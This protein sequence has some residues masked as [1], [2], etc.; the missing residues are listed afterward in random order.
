MED[1]SQTSGMILLFG[2]LAF[3]PAVVDL[4]G[5]SAEDV[6][7]NGSDLV[8]P[9]IVVLIGNIIRVVFGMTSIFIGF[10]Y[11]VCRW[12]SKLTST[13]GLM[14]TMAAWFPFAA[15]IVN[16]IFN[17]DK[18][19][20]AAP[21]LVI[22][23]DAYSPTRAE[24]RSIASD[25]SN[26]PPPHLLLDAGALTFLHWKNWKFYSGESYVYNAGYYLSRQLYY[27]TIVIMEG[28]AQLAF[29]EH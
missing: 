5:S 7:W 6:D 15:T 8:F 14:I 11:T 12:G 21:P 3:V 26:V 27:G 2:I 10:Q 24:V 4:I 18:E 29:G 23:P 13:F 28:I 17:A 1:M 25:G 22:P 16:I 9:P 19:L 20:T